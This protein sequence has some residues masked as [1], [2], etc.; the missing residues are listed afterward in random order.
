[1][2]TICQSWPTGIN[3]NRRLT[4]DTAHL[5]S[6]HN[7]RCTIV[8]S[9][10]PGHGEAVPKTLEVARASSDF[11]FLLVDNVR[12]VEISST[13]DGMCSQFCH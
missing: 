5:L 6:K 9:P 10:D 8:G 7:S 1:M 11:Q 12:V 4:I 13:D 2:T 3:Q